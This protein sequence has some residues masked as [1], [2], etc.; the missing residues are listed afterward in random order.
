[1]HII[2]QSKMATSNTT[3]TT[4]ATSSVIS[5]S[6]SLN[7]MMMNNVNDNGS[8]VTTTSNTSCGSTNSSTSGLGL[9]TGSDI[10]S[11][12]TC[13]DYQTLPLP[14]P[15]PPPHLQI[16]QKHSH[17]E[18]L[19]I[20][21]GHNLQPIQTN[22][23]SISSSSRPSI[24]SP[25]ISS[26]SSGSPSS[27]S[28]STSS[29]G[30]G[31]GCI[32]HQPLSSHATNY[33][34]YQN[35]S[36]LYSTYAV[37]SQLLN[38]NPHTSVQCI[39]LELEKDD[40][41]ELG[42][43]ITGR[44]AAD[45]TLGYVVAGLETGSPAHRC[46]Q[47]EK[48]DEVLTI[49][50][51]LLRGLNVND[52][53]HH[54]KSPEKLV[55]IVLV[56]Q[57]SLIITTPSSSSSSSSTGQPQQLYSAIYQNPKQLYSSTATIQPLPPPPS[58]TSSSS[59]NHQL[60]GE[61]DLDKMALITISND[62][63]RNNKKLLEKSMPTSITN[64]NA[65][66]SSSIT[67]G[68]ND[69]NIQSSS[70]STL[71]RSTS[72]PS[73]SKKSL[74]ARLA[75]LLNR[76][77]NNNNN[78]NT[79]MTRKSNNKNHTL[80]TSYSTSSISTTASNKNKNG[81][82]H[83]TNN[84]NNDDIIIDYDDYNI[85]RT[86]KIRSKSI[87]NMSSSISVPNDLSGPNNNNS[88]TKKVHI[89][90]NNKND[91][92]DN[93]SSASA[94]KLRYI[95]LNNVAGNSIYGHFS[96]PNNNNNTTV[97]Y[98]QPI[99]S[100]A[101]ATMT[102]RQ[103]QDRLYN[104]YVAFKQLQVQQVNQQQQQNPNHYYYQQFIHHNNNNRSII[105]NGSISPLSQALCTLPRTNKPK[106]LNLI[107][108][109]TTTMNMMVETKKS[110]GDHVDGD[111]Q[112]KQSNQTSK[113]SCISYAESLLSPTMLQPI[114]FPSIQDNNNNIGGS[115]CEN[116]GKSNNN[117]GAGGNGGSNRIYVRM[118]RQS[119]HHDNNHYS[120]Q[121]Q[122]H[123]MTL[124]PKVLAEQQQNGHHHLNYNHQISLESQPQTITF[125]KGPDCK[126]LG[127]SIVGGIDSPRGEMAIYVKTVFPEGQA[128]ESGQLSEGD[129]ILSINGQ[130]TDN[131][132][133]GEVLQMF[134]RVKQ[135]EIVLRILRLNSAMKF[136]NKCYSSS[137]A[138]GSGGG[139]GGGG[140]GALSRSCFD[141]DLITG[142]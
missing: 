131:L 141:L 42:I 7:D 55:R 122:Q 77:I 48:N 53:L 23:M 45:G 108:N 117:N 69:N 98:S 139:G 63:C 16:S 127:F 13:G 81:N 9:G 68:N 33:T 34:T 85:M 19:A 91:R 64:N 66:Q 111:L 130:S 38:K 72:A 118:N 138:N 58:S 116:Y 129:Q 89:I 115:S 113:D 90:A 105:D 135:G 132:T 73:K 27:S 3:T 5:S 17:H 101:A 96:G 94:C 43:F 31:G 80:P 30:S 47:I 61:I 41:G 54:L 1:M 82:H 84:N 70:T 87:G 49:N 57:R 103:H 24:Y 4:L 46:G 18:L 142:K 29:S 107:N 11:S 93:S 76:K 78:N 140:G 123:S 59:T 60:S 26:S 79:T 28:S 44:R 6:T 92:S 40:K 95:S 71:T 97:Q 56:K 134:K 37:P 126:A 74:G 14:P 39:N 128:A 52:A 114:I 36:N 8:C 137:I 109:N 25:F 75:S 50:G 133:H 136:S 119:S 102:T 2:H 10:S 99:A 83:E 120:K 32:V 106:Q 62:D 20:A 65:S 35:I 22:R 12:S 51:I 21:T 110:N 15:P 125:K 124:N 112:H 104:P 88:T 121:Q 86:P 67:P 100:T